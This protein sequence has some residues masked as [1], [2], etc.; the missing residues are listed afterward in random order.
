MVN[1]YFPSPLAG[2]GQGEGAIIG[3]R[4]EHPNPTPKTALG[5]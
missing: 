3:E 4:S 2:E 5:D 1:K